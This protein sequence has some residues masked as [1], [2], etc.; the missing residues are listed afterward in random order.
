MARVREKV[1]EKPKWITEVVWAQLLAMWGDDRYITNRCVAASNRDS[2]VGGSFHTQ[3][4]KNQP[5]HE[6]ELVSKQVQ[7][8]RLGRIPHKGELFKMC[9]SWK[10]SQTFVDKR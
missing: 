10:G 1:S 8:K 4:S 3:G 7:S 2:D 9:H 6:L 5:E